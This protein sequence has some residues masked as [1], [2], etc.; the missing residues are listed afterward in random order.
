MMSTAEPIIGMN[1]MCNGHYITIYEKEQWLIPLD[2][3]GAF[4]PKGELRDL[5]M[6]E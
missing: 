4:M 5:D 2:Q 3:N 1:E 6:C